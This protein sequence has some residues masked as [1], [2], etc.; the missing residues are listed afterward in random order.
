MEEFLHIVDQGLVKL[1]VTLDRGVRHL[2]T[3]LEICLGSPAIYLKFRLQIVQIPGNAGLNGLCVTGKA[4]NHDICLIQ[5]D[6][7]G[8]FIQTGVGLGL[9]PI[10]FMGLLA[11]GIAFLLPLLQQTQ[12]FYSAFTGKQH[13]CAVLPLT[14]HD[15]VQQAIALDSV[16]QLL[17]ALVIIVAGPEVMGVKF[18]VS[19]EDPGQFRAFVLEGHGD[20][21]FCQMVFGR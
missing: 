10:P 7:F 14:D 11:G 1:G 9:H 12:G 6:E 2:G 18:N 13:K 8:Q 19:Q 3:G 17:D 5:N 21:R 20:L 15:V 16:R 4:P